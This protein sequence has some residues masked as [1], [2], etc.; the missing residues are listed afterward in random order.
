M[1]RFPCLLAN[2]RLRAFGIGLLLLL[3]AMTVTAIA[4]TSLTRS[5]KPQ[6]T[7][8]TIDLLIGDQPLTVEVAST[9]IQRYMGLSFRQELEDDAGMLFAYPDEQPLTF[10]M[11]NT[12][13]PLSIAF[14]S[15]ELVV[16]EIHDMDVG[17]NQ[18]FPARQPAM[19]ALEV[20]QGWFERHDIEAGAT[21]EMI[22]RRH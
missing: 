16:N 8:P 1:S 3:G 12:L 9:S 11:R 20:K 4:Q 6:P 15:E 14:I 22:L 2:R 17:P 13:L 5:D 7:L 19:Y 10:T 21:I 18:L